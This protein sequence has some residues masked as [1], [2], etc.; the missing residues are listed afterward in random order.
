MKFGLAHIVPPQGEIVQDSTPQFPAEAHLS[1]AFHFTISLMCPARTGWDPPFALEKGTNGASMDSFCFGV[2]KQLTSHLCRRAAPP[3]ASPRSVAAAAAAAGERC[4]GNRL[5]GGGGGGSAVAAK[6]ML[7]VGATISADGDAEAAAASSRATDFGF[8][9]LAKQ[10]TLRSFAAYADWAQAMH[11]TE[12]APGE[13][14]PE[15]RAA[16]EAAAGGNSRLLQPPGAARLPR[17]LADATAVPGV[18]EPTLEQVRACQ[19]SS[20]L[21]KQSVSFYCPIALFWHPQQMEAEFWR[22]VESP[23]VPVASLYGQDLDSG[24]HGSGFPLPAWRRRL[25]EANLGSRGR[26]VELPG[27]DAADQAW[28]E[29]PWN[30]GNM[31]MAHGSVL[32]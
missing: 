9:D 17:S 14:P 3:H 19:R 21:W 6:G 24:H 25:L 2:R 28:A 8:V 22:I 26:K 5:S 32:R 10:H 20:E 13:E 27:A 29:H 15:A 30:V 11:F 23:D 16:S 1:A 7:P 12:P 4:A 31:P 18:R